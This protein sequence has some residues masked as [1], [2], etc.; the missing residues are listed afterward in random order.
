MKRF[1]VLCAISFFPVLSSAKTATTTRPPIDPLVRPPLAPGGTGSIRAP[2]WR[3]NNQPNNNQGRAFNRRAPIPELELSEDIFLPDTLQLMARAGELV[4]VDLVNKIAVG[5]AK[6]EMKGASP[7]EARRAGSKIM[8]AH[9]RS[10]L[11]NWDD[12]VKQNLN[13]L[14]DDFS[15]NGI[16][17][18]NRGQVTDVS[19]S[20]PVPQQGVVS[21]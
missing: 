13:N 20:C 5:V 6:A 9:I 11:E 19:D 3:G 4:T 7:R 18:Y 1:I 16:T 21:I 8:N 17:E 15:R 14:T 10:G 12:A 2:I